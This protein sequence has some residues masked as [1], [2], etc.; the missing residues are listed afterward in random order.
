MEEA[1]NSCLSGLVSLEAS[2]YTPGQFMGSNSWGLLEEWSPVPLLLLL[3]LFQGL[4]RNPCTSQA[5]R[6]LLSVQGRETLI[7]VLVF[8][9]SG[10]P[11]RVLGRGGRIRFNR[12]SQDGWE[13]DGGSY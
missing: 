11:R 13:M 4:L 2:S 6:L 7:R 8:Q 10:N 1:A 3:A 9:T 5:S 12:I